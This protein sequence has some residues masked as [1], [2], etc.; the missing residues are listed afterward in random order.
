MKTIPQRDLRNRSGEI[1]RE[2]ER[3]EQITITVEG[4]PVAVLGPL[5]RRQWLPRA[6]FA[7]ILHS[8]A[9]DPSFA[10]DV[11]ELGGTLADL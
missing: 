1:L 4:R 5:P 9:P 10:A 6:E 11:A 3:G 8:G 2:A 7:R